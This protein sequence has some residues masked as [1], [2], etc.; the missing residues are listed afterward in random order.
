MVR[1]IS[2][3]THRK[4]RT[5]S[6]LEKLPD[7]VLPAPFFGSQR[8]NST[9]VVGH[10]ALVKKHGEKDGN[11]TNVQV[12]ISPWLEFFSRMNKNYPGI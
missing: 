9:L 7:P 2:N 3:Q 11:K 6:P 8:G 4:L 1:I 5:E 12:I 10:G